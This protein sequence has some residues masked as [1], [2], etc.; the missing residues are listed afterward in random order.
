MTKL[1]LGISCSLLISTACW[2]DS[3]ENT[4]TFKEAEHNRGNEIAVQGTQNVFSGEQTGDKGKVAV[5]VD[6]E[7]N[8]LH[9]DQDATKQKQTVKVSM[10][11]QNNSVTISQGVSRG[12]ESGTSVSRPNETTSK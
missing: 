1:L 8:T 3:S 6:G 7:T 12:A 11:G 9:I 2:A 5:K 10:K 4:V